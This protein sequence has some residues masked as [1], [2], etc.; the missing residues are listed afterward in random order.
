MIDRAVDRRADQL[1]KEYLSKARHADQNF[2]GTPEGEVG[3]VERK[4]LTFPKVEGLVF[5]NWREGS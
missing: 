3:R 2:G 4:L 5:G 1:H